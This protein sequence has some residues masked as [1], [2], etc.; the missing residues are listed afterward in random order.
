MVTLKQIAEECGIDLDVVRNVL[1]EA[2]STFKV[3]RD[4][5]DQIFKTARKLGYDFKKLKLGKRMQVRKETVEEILGRISENP[6]WGRSEIV[7]YLKSLSGMVD[8]VQ[9]RAFR[10]EYGGD[11]W[12]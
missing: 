7:R 4:L 5:Q 6:E 11:D 8:R 1:K 2:S 12:L 3:A 10:E 9:K